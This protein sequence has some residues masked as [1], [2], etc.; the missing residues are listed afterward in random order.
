MSISHDFP[1]KSGEMSILNF[2]IITQKVAWQLGG[3]QWRNNAL[4]V[5]SDGKFKYVAFLGWGGS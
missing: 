3:K 5:T 1:I 4:L 2:M